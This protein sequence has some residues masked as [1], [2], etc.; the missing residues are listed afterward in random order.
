MRVFLLQFQAKHVGVKEDK[1]LHRPMN[2]IQSLTLFCWGSLSCVFLECFGPLCAGEFHPSTVSPSKL[3]IVCNDTY[4]YRY[5]YVLIYVQRYH[6]MYISYKHIF[7][8]FSISEHEKSIVILHIKTISLG[9]NQ[10]KCQL[11]TGRE[12]DLEESSLDN[13]AT[14]LVLFLLPHKK[15]RGRFAVAKIPRIRAEFLGEF[16]ESLKWSGD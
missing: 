14:W 11:P 3:R 16:F 4:M 12:E 8:L 10:Q 5:I 9:R 13:E 6:Y 1:R 7:F 2:S 15:T